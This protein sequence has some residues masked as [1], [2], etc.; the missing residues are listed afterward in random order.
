MIVASRR[1]PATPFGV[2]EFMRFDAATM[3]ASR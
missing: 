3:P 2:I 1:G